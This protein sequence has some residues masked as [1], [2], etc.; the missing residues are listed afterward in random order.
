MLM[1]NVAKQFV[2]KKTGKSLL[3]E[4][5]IQKLGEKLDQGIK[6]YEDH[7]DADQVSERE[8]TTLDDDT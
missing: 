1:Q 7:E 8:E 2:D 5:N 3:N 6:L 4:N